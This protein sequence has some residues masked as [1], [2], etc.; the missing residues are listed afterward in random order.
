MEPQNEIRSAPHFQSGTRQYFKRNK[1]SAAI[2]WWEEGRALRSS[3]LGQR[4]QKDRGAVR[5]GRARGGSGAL[6][7][8]LRALSSL[9]PKRRGSVVFVG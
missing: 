1:L 5:S 2:G 9:V 4:E 6:S 7:P 8:A 3:Q